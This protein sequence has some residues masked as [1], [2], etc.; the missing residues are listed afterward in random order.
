MVEESLEQ[1]CEI[2]FNKLRPT[3]FPTAYFEKD[4]DASSGTKGDYIFKDGHKAH[5]FCGNPR[6]KLR[7]TTSYYFIKKLFLK[8]AFNAKDLRTNKKN[9]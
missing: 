8:H 2:E 7:F 3:A 6:F 9:S 5:C 4:N 1:H